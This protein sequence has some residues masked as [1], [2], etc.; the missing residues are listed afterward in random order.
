MFEG[1]EELRFDTGEA[2]I[3][4]RAGGSGPPILL[5][6]GHPR[7]HATWHRVAADLARD[8]TVV[9]P[10]L[11]GYG[12]SSKPVT[13]SDHAPYAKRAMAIDLVALMRHLGFQN[14]V[15]VG[16]DRGA[17][18]SFRLA[19]DH[20][21]CVGRLVIMDAVPIGDALARA[22]TTFASAWWHWFFYGQ[23]AKP[24][25]RV[26]NA[27][28]V[29]WY[30][31]TDEHMGAEAFAD[32]RAAIHNPETVH[33]M[34]EDYRAGLGIDRRHDDEDRA[35]GRRLECPVLFIRAE[36]DDLADLYDDP[37]AIWRIWADEV[38]AETLSCGHHMAEE[39]PVELA[40]LIRDFASAPEA[41]RID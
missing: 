32:Y 24:A 8:F 28:P 20:P 3:Y 39:Q 31:D 29:A 21:G 9:C 16:H 6:H 30:G 38:R 4:A 2:E 40:R 23:I 34:L 22:G 36:R 37:A 35:A 25:E 14:W 19:L 26:I 12:R 17:Y 18:V 1:F 11:R 5:V 13:T 15:Q 27:D 10:D 41:R 7:T 33:A